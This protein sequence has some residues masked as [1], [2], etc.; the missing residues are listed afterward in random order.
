MA[1]DS[2]QDPAAMFREFVTQWERNVNS[3]A[4]QV[5]GTESF[6]RMMQEAQRLQLALQQATSE[7]MG[8]RLAA[9]NMPTRDDVIRLAEKL[10]EVDR[11][12]ARIEAIARRRCDARARRRAARRP[13]AHPPAAR[14]IPAEGETA[15]TIPNRRAT[16]TLGARMR[17]NGRTRDS[18]WREGL[19][20]RDV[21]SREGRAHAEND[22]VWAR[23]AAAV[24]L[25]AAG[26]RVVSRAG[27]DGDG[28]HEQ[29]VRVRPAAG[30]EHGRVPAEAR[31]RR[32]RRRLESAGAG[33][34]RP[35]ARRLHA[36]LH[37][38]VHPQ[39]AAGDGP[40]RRLA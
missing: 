39:S 21:G 33:R 22:A 4:N 12:L 40:D 29:G 25:H 37:S 31:L 32:V 36:G 20:V 30:P 7:A 34:A 17:G 15:M 3:F 9:M 28:D 2:P 18:A 38:D 10:A 5:M 13:A 8:R 11:R 35:H 16:T 1:N 19:S 14:R 27:A 6:S 23:H 24:S 26:R